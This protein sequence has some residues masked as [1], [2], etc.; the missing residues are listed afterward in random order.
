MS[1]LAQGWGGP[2]AWTRDSKSAEDQLGRGF[3]LYQHWVQQGLLHLETSVPWPGVSFGQAELGLGV[4]GKPVGMDHGSFLLL[5]PLNQSG[6]V[7]S[8]RLPGH[9]S[10]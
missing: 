2:C 4:H 5:F 6:I 3:Q 8:P 10:P 1:E 9:D 7:S